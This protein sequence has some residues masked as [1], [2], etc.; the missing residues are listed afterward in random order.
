MIKEVKDRVKIEEISEVDGS[1]SYKESLSETEKTKHV[2]YSV[3][4]MK[5]IKC[6]QEAQARIETLEAKVAANE[7]G[8]TTY[9]AKIDKIIDYFKL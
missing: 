1:K 5:A 9:N 4:Y 3:L 2:M 7:A 8:D 6:L